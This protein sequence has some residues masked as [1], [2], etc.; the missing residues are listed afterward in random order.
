MIYECIFYLDS[1][2][3]LYR[4]YQIHNDASFRMYSDV[5]APCSTLSK[6]KHV[7]TGK[8]KYVNRTK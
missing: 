5:F 4:V 3:V 7:G 1:R 2:L 8:M 6:L